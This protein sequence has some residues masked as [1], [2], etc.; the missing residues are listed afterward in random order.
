MSILT[1]SIAIFCYAKNV[2]NNHLLLKF[3]WCIIFLFESVLILLNLIKIV[4]V[5]VFIP[6]LLSTTINCESKVLTLSIQGLLIQAMVRK[7]I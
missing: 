1:H 4:Q 5:L 7:K 3:D 2:I 6:S